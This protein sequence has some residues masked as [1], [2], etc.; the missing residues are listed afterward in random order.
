[1][2]S[3][4]KKDEVLTGYVAMRIRK[5]QQDGTPLLHLS[6]LAGV[7]RSLLNNIRDGKHGIGSGS[8]EGFAKALGFEDALQLR[9]EAKKWWAS[10][11]SRAYR[12][13]VAAKQSAAQSPFAGHTGLELAVASR[14]YSATVIRQAQELARELP[15][16]VG[17]EDWQD[18]LDAL[19]REHRRMLRA[20][21]VS[22]KAESEPP[23]SNEP[24]SDVHPSLPPPAAPSGP[25]RRAGAKLRRA[26]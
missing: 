7:S 2:A 5:W 8:D 9:T 11:E 14:T 13:H 20:A 16:T 19:E 22:P 10:P 24:E 3:G 23:P 1:M 12:E 6:N 25:A 18:Y 26:R 17:T 15:G 4:R 21:R